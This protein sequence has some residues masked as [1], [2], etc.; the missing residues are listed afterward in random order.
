MQTAKPHPA[1]FSVREP[2]GHY[3]VVYEL[4]MGIDSGDTV[5]LVCVQEYFRNADTAA[6]REV[7]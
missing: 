6:L 7:V 1:V 5:S 2:S 4:E 3:L